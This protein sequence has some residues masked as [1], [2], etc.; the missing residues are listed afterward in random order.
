MVC[1][2]S[3]AALPELLGQAAPSKPAPPKVDQALRARVT[4]FHQYQMEG[5][6]RKAYDLVAKD[7]QDFFFS[8]SKEKP[9]VF[10]IE[11]IEYSDKF[12]KAVIKVSTTNRALV[13]FHTIDLPTVVMDHWR[14]EGGKWMW[15]HDPQ[16]D[17]PNFFGLPVGESSNPEAVLAQSVP[18]DTS[19][20]AVTT[21]AQAAL[22]GAADRPPL[23]KDSLEFTLGTPGTQQVLVRNN[24]RGPVWLA[25]SVPGE[26][27]GLTVEPAE[28]AI[29]ALG[30][31]SVK[32][33]YL[34]LYRD[35]A[36]AV[37]SFQ[38]R[39]FPKV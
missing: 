13:G 15:Y 34:A 3:L 26:S 7:S 4:E 5:N 36:N 30:E 28:V 2:A 6:F 33:H 27:V 17:R 39:P 9:A 29:D 21:A 24:Y 25:A 8:T 20:Q 19:P 10:K 16:G 18:K 14:L 37:V 23:D 31:V 22:Q 1:V 11:E 32:V 38:L 35:P 12:T